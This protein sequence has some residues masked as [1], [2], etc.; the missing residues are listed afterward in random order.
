MYHRQNPLA[1]KQKQ[2]TTFNIPHVKT[3]PQANQ[4]EKWNHEIWWFLVLSSPPP[5]FPDFP[6]LNWNSSAPE[7]L[8]ALEPRRSSSLEL[9]G[10]GV[11]YHWTRAT[12]HSLCAV[13]CIQRELAIFDKKGYFYTLQSLQLSLFRWMIETNSNF[14]DPTPSHLTPNPLATKERSIVKSSDLLNSV[15]INQTPAFKSTNL[16][17]VHFPQAP[18][19]TLFPFP[20]Y[21]LSNPT[22]NTPPRRCISRQHRKY[23]CESPPKA[24]WRSFLPE[25]MSRRP[26]RWGV[27]YLWS[28]RIKYVDWCVC[29][30]RTRWL[31]VDVFFCFFFERERFVRKLMDDDLDSWMNWEIG[32]AVV[33]PTSI[34]VS[35]C[36]VEVLISPSKIPT[37]TNNKSTNHKP[38]RYLGPGENEDPVTVDLYACKLL[39]FDG[40]S[41]SHS[42]PDAKSYGIRK[43]QSSPNSAC[44][45]LVITLQHYIQV[46]RDRPRDIKSH[47]SDARPDI[48]S[49]PH[50]HHFQL[51]FHSLAFRINI[52]SIYYNPKGSLWRLQEKDLITLYCTVRTPVT[53]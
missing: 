22:I 9:S 19:W 51:L 50:S 40:L 2:L 7:E 36:V 43:C 16:R 23:S 49:G 1:A 29:V 10:I 17:W 21:P 14:S 15:K 33:E 44:W 26:K 37:I 11:T 28:S 38:K 53:Q 5:L 31:Y 32:G 34:D 13:P 48:S 20:P 45:R 30:S 52:S 3:Q 8:N 25:I 18:N 27:L 39:A 12:G 46:L 24:S 42:I 47:D 6:L 41:Q 35:S 4:I